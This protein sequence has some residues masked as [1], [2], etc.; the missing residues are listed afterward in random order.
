MTTADVETADT[1]T[2]SEDDSMRFS[3][4]TGAWFLRVQEQAILTM[5]S[6]YPDASVLDVG[7]GHGQMTDAVIR[8]GHRVEVSGSSDACRSRIQPIID[9]GRCSF[10]SGDLLHLPYPDQAF[11]VSCPRCGDVC[12]AVARHSTRGTPALGRVVAPH[13]QS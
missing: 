11:D 9:A 12:R 7:G 4:P 5:L 6:P 8:Q 3:G 1:E 13:F 10:M 2:S